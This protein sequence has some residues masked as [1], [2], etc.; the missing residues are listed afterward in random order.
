MRYLALCI[1]F[2]TIQFLSAQGFYDINTI[3]KIEVF[4]P[5]SNWDAKMDSTGITENYMIATQVKVNGVTFDSVGVKYKGN[6]SFN[7]NNKK[8]P[9]HIELDHIKSN[10]EYE[11]Y[12]DIK[13]GNNFQDPSFMREVLGYSILK[14]YMHCPRGNFV[15][16]YVNNVYRGLYTN[17]ES[18]G[19]TFL[20]NHFYS[21]DGPFFKCNKPSFGGPG[22]PNLVPSA[23][24]TMSD[25]ISYYGVRYEIKSD[26][27]WKSFIQAQLELQ[28][29]IDTLWD[30]DRALWMF[31]FNNVFVNLDSYTGSFTQNYYEYMDEYKKF[32]SIVWDI[33]M[34]IGSF[35][36]LG[37][38]PALSITQMQQMSPMANSTSTT[39]PLISKLLAKPRYS[40]QYVA[41]LRTMTYEALASNDYYTQATS[42]KNL[43]SNDVN[44]D[45]LKFY[46]YA[47]FLT[48]IDTAASTGGFGTKVGIKQLLQNRYNYLKNTAEFSQVPPVISNIFL[49]KN[50]P[51]LNDTVWIRAKFSNAN[52]AYL[53]LR[54]LTAKH[55]DRINMFDDGAHRDSLAGDGIYGIS[56]IVSAG[57]MEYYFYGE[58]NNAGI[59]SPERAEHEFY[60]L[61]A[62]IPILPANSIVINEL[63]ASN[64]NSF[65]DPSGEREDW[66]ELKNTT[67]A[68]INLSGMYLSDDSIN[69]AKWPFPAGTQILPND[70][71]VVWLDEDQSQP[72]LH[73]NFKLSSNGERLRIGYAN[74][75]I[76][77]SIV[78][79]KQKA[80]SSYGRCDDAVGNFRIITKPTPKAINNCTADTLKLNAVLDIPQERF[81]VYPNP[82]SDYL[83]ISSEHLIKHISIRNMLGSE[84]WNSVSVGVFYEKIDM[85]DFAPGVYL[86]QINDGK[87]RKLKVE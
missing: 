62:N 67:N 12:T 45:S 29:G 20:A 42:I 22:S 8:N 6:S 59:F 56:F 21:K 69:L 33:N 14:N 70:Y 53:G 17:Q 64:V 3:Q 11:G 51:Q 25:S 55:F 23:N 74:G 4:F 13:L 36:Q 66:V 28:S 68:T 47:A 39:R 43:I 2:F 16:L 87:V 61:I 50:S 34:C 63:M 80:D 79:P 83:I 72:G 86:L 18:I 57:K 82:T 1:S 65:K 84:L 48:N 46:T 75:A 85:M 40:K 73:A 60:S 78:F 30:V 44:A 71:M 10:Q 41:H 77:D 32:N 15:N 5:M 58:N 38:G 81:E 37:T 31:T 7:V 27:G 54:N 52:Y 26:W 19:K 76:M 24:L 9:W 35:T 49:D